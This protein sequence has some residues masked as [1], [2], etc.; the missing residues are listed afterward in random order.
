LRTARLTSRGRLQP[1]RIN[2]QRQF[3]QVPQVS[4]YELA[5]LRDIPERGLREIHAGGETTY[6][7]GNRRPCQD[8]V[9]RLLELEY[10]IGLGDGLFEPVCQTYGVNTR[11]A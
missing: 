5:L 10:V 9:R 11:T 4:D 6:W 1:P 3:L 8:T 7:I 2:H